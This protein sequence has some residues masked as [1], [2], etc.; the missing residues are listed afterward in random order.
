MID[1]HTHVL[2]GIDDGPVTVEESLDVLRAAVA[3]GIQTLAATPHVSRKYPT[4]AD[5]MEAAVEALRD[6]A[7]THGLPIQLIRGGELAHDVLLDLDGA[8]LRRFALGGANCLLVEFPYE[9]WPPALADALR[10]TASFG[11]RPVLAH[12]E[13]NQEVQRAP[14]RLRALVANGV[15]LQVTAASVE[16]RLGPEAARAAR[17]LIDLG[18]VHLLSSDAHGFSVRPYGLRE[19]CRTLRDPELADSLTRKNPEALLAGRE[20]AATRRRAQR[21]R[22]RW[23]T[24]IRPR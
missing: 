17:E 15:L 13:R 22:G 19:A 9:V 6:Q 21:R 7:R 2:P 23:A 24:L 5:R 18:L 8:E 12:P 1:L 11:L 16:G 20:V 3:E 10:R 14:E 4:T